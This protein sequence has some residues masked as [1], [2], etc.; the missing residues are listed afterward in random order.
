MFVSVKKRK[1]ES[2]KTLNTL[3]CAPSVPLSAS[4]VFANPLPHTQQ[5]LICG[6]PRLNSCPTHQSKAL[7]EFQC[8]HL[9]THCLSFTHLSSLL[10]SLSCQP[11]VERV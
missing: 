3:I 5:G 10:R 2:Q 9:R 1:E 6:M 7:N 8:V 11:S 4:L